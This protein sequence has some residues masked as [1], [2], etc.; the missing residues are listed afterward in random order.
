MDGTDRQ[1][2][3]L[4]LV[5]GPARSAVRI[6][7][8]LDGQVGNRR[9]YDSRTPRRS[10]FTLM[11]CALP[12]EEGKQGLFPE[13]R[14]FIKN[15]MKEIGV[16]RGEAAV[17]CTVPVLPTGTNSEWTWVFPTCSLATPTGLATL[18]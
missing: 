13:T 18:L 1:L 5:Q 11:I 7:G 4:R 10:S 12:L 14:T 8:G 17:T 2:E 6:N 16:K 3:S 15:F 9:G